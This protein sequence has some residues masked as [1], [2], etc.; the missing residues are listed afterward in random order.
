MTGARLVGTLV[1]GL[2]V[3]DQSL[4]IATACVAGGQGI[5]ILVERVG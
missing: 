5:S 1:R 4:G 2:E 3:R